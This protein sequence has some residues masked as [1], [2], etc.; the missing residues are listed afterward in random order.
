[1]TVSVARLTHALNF[2]A[3]KHS[4]QRRKGAQAE[5]YINHLIEVADLLARAGADEETL[6]AGILHDTVE[7][8]ETTYDEL[9]REF[10]ENVADIVMECTDDKSLEKQVRKQLQVEHAPHKSASAKMVKMADKISNLRSIL[11]SPPPAWDDA[12]KLEYF[13][14]SNRVILGCRTANSQLADVYDGLYKQGLAK[15][16]PAA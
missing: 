10:G 8:T 4:D 9:K 3:R 11:L 14:W 12:R 7:D 13:E 6:L 5:P 15:F 16:K 1:M 2:A